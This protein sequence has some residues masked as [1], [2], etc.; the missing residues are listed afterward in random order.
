MYHHDRAIAEQLR[1]PLS[2]KRK[3]NDIYSDMID[4]WLPQGPHIHDGKQCIKKRIREPHRRAAK[5]L[6]KK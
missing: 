6:K 1:G 4:E 2:Y 3:I 5:K